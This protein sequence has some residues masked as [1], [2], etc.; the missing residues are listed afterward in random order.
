MDSWMKN[1][2]RLEDIFNVILGE[3]ERGAVLLAVHI[4]DD[5]LAELI[6]DTKPAHVSKEIFKDVTNFGGAFGSISGKSKGLY[7]LGLLS[8]QSFDAINALRQ[9]R[10][11]AAHSGRPFLIADHQGKFDVAIKSFGSGQQV[12][13]LA[14]EIA[15]KQ[16]L[17]KMQEVG[18]KLR[19]E[20][21]KNPFET[22]DECIDYLS[23]NEEILE[24]L[25]AKMP[26]WHVATLTYIIIEAAHH[27]FE[28]LTRQPVVT[29][30]DRSA[31]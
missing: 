10:N 13:R 20:L 17:G 29:D 5:F 27:S 12:K 15:M 22:L 21:G 19:E 28:R 7:V 18:E 11:E 8:K 25:E 4:I 23:D 3:S 24:K 26:L 31:D 1:T 9:V 14:L 16:H 30:T 6:K 2:H